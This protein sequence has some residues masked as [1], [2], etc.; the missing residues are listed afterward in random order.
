MVEWLYSYQRQNHNGNDAVEP[1]SVPEPDF[2][3]ISFLQVRFVVFNQI[4]FYCLKNQTR[5][6]KDRL[7][8][9]ADQHR[10]TR[11]REKVR[12]PA[13]VTRRRWVEEKP[14]TEEV[15]EKMTHETRVSE[16]RGGLEGGA[17]GGGGAGHG[18]KRIRNRS[19]RNQ[20][21]HWCFMSVL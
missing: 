7:W 8:T 18:R 21:N 12:V 14:R 15:E 6:K 11:V 20:L 19:I 13:A 5:I 17:G 3:K 9:S 4:L 2:I 1:S 10:S 16:Q